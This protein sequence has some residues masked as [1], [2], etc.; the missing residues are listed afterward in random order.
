MSPPNASSVVINSTGSY[1][2]VVTNTANGCSS[3]AVFDVSCAVGIHENFKNSPFITLY[4]NPVNDKLNLT[5]MNFNSSTKN[6][7][8]INDVNGNKVIEYSVNA[9]NSEVP[10]L[11][12]PAGFYFAE[13]IQDNKIIY[14]NKFIKN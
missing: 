1:S 10:L 9:E 11:F 14:R 7:F 4:P 6:T 8:V 13:L 12:L 5:L 3:Q 2:C